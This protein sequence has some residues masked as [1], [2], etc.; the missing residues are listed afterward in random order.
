MNAQ[1]A[2]K[3]KE[4][5]VYHSM[6]LYME[7]MNVYEKL[8]ENDD[9]LD[10]ESRQSIQEKI[11]ILKKEIEKVEEQDAAALT[12]D[13]ISLIKETLASAA[14]GGSDLYDS[15]KA[16]RELGLYSEAYAEYE[17]LLR[18]DTDPDRYLSD[19]LDCALKVRS[20]EESFNQLKKIIQDKEAEVNEKTTLF[21]E[22][23][24]ELENRGHSGP[25][26]QSYSA[27]IGLDPKNKTAKERLKAL[28][29]SLA[30]GSRYDFLLN[31][32]MVTTDQLKKALEMSKKMNKS[33]E[34][35]LIE[36]FRISKEDVG[37]SLALYYGCPFK[38]YDDKTPTPVELISKLKK[39]FL[40]QEHWV[41]LSWDKSGVEVLLDDPRDLN[42]TDNLRALL[43][44]KVYFAVGIREDIDAYI[45]LFFDDKKEGG[46]EGAG[47]RLNGEFDM[48]PEISFEEDQEVEDEGE[49]YDEASGQVVRLVDQVLVAA[50]RQ[51]ASDIHVEPS[52]VT[53]ATSIRFRMDGVCQEYLQVPNSLARGIL[54]R[55]KIMAGLDIA[56]RRLPQ[57][58]KIKFKRKGVD[59]FELR[60]ATLPTAGGFEDTVLRILA[61]AGAMKMEE[62]GLSERN[63]RVLKRVINQP[64][65]LILV[66]GPTGSGKTTSLHACLGH[67]NKPGVKIWT[68]EDPVEITQI[69]LRQVEAKPKIGLD[70]A[71]I[72]RA[73]LRADP[74]IIMIGEMRDHETASIGVEA[75]LTGHLVFST[76]HTN[77]APETVT[78]LLD[79]GLNALNFSDAFLGVMAQRLARRLCMNCKEAYRPSR[80]EFDEIVQ[81]FGK[82]QWEKTGIEYNSDL[83]LYRP[84]GCEKC[85]STGYKGRLGI[86]E[87]MEGTKEIKALI[88]HAEETEKLFSVAI[89]QGMNTLKQDGILKAFQGITDVA[90]IRRICIN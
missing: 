85:S 15:A 45:R 21:N 4:A 58:G 5:E 65:G 14:S 30:T 56:E 44:A 67:I 10:T 57:D 27:A 69:G 60:V 70:F 76:L 82:A 89:E 83:T 7:S 38:I 37:E 88:K 50:Y 2:S 24:L 41:P 17:N 19:M 34:T 13:E 75:S 73:F 79:M 81:D 25:A 51:G 49:E 71:R 61:K 52:P 6:G 48:M 9:N 11:D 72:M 12:S 80:E 47:S 63:L 77:S 90:E 39:P 74:D 54:S 86:H 87:L 18:G 66:V 1:I 68:A 3:I 33:V 62:M 40:L 55:I 36:Q 84:V 29:A 26:M 16:F 35:I 64:Y 59:P 32:K 43:K 42:K 78:R 8:L 53:K 23:G 22:L 28:K 46:G 20:A 31:Q